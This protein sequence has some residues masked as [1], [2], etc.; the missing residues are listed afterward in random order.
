M[1]GLFWRIF[2]AFWLANVAIIIALTWITSNK[3]ES[4]KIPGLE[5]TR[6][7]A[8]MD[9]QL[10]KLAREAR[11][12]GA[13]KLDTSLKVTASMSPVTFYAI[14][15][16]NRD[17]LDRQIPSAVLEALP[18]LRADPATAQERMRSVRTTLRDDG[19]ELLLVAITEGSLFAKMLYR[20]SFGFWTHIGLI[21]IAST[22]TS[23]LIAWYV[24]S[25][26]ARI[27]ASTRRF[28]EGDL[29]ARVGKLHL[30]RST[31]MSALAREFDRMAERIK[32]LIENNR[33]LVRD[34]SHELRSPLARVRVALE[35]AREQKEPA[36]G[37][38]LDRIEI[39]SDRLE[40]ML[41]QTIELSRLE[42]RPEL[43]SEPIRLDEVVRDVIENACYEGASLGRR[44]VIHD[45]IPAVTQGS[46]AALDSAIENIVRNA[47]AYTNGDVPIEVSISRDS[48]LPNHACIRIRDHGPGVGE[49]DLERIFEP[50]YRTDSARTR[51]SGGTGLG[52]A[53]ARRAV[54]NMG[55][56]I[57]ARN[58][59]GGGLEV[60]IR[61]PETAAT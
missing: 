45:T 38:S 19:S 36:L 57:E 14:D 11:R 33:R 58:A 20:R 51:S 10:A 25:P 7:Q 55:G 12:F 13:E 30:G 29:D 18:A 46:R 15:A 5:I 39:E 61:L 31:E 34:V 17:R 21:L 8:A 48:K 28:A 35:L 56:N 9:D 37:Q 52:L 24:A 44:I 59:D 42:T 2:G 40:A 54:V 60:L 50:F 53:I 23:A 43:H 1:Q 32:A 6:M 16:Q 3:F 26:L 47:I 49:K 41:A 27:R 4:E 22:L